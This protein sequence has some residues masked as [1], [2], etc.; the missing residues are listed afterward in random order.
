MNSRNQFIW[1]MVLEADMSKIKELD[2]L[3]AFFLS[4][5]P[6]EGITNGVVC[7]CTRQRERVQ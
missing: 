6:V 7:T 3:G 5:H 4:R 1:F 2:L